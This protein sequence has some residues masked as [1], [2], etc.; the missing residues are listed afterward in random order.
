MEL[1]LINR[2]KTGATK[3]PVFVRM[4]V[5]ENSLCGEDFMMA[6]LSIIIMLKPENENSDSIRAIFW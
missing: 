1:G 6:G 4:R 2:L 5:K 3:A